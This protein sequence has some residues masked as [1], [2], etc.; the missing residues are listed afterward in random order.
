MRFKSASVPDEMKAIPQWVAYFKK[1]VSGEAHPRKIMVSPNTFHLAKSNVPSDWSDYGKAERYMR[2]RG[3][4]GLAFVLTEGIVF[5][6]LDG[7]IDSDGNI[8]HFATE[9]LSRFSGTYSERS[10]SGHGIHIFARGKLPP[11]SMKRNDALGLEMYETKR[12]CCVTGDAIGASKE[13]VDFSPQIKATAEE[14]LGHKVFVE[15][16]KTDFQ[17]LSMSDQELL[18]RVSKSRSGAKFMKLYAGDASDYPSPS[19][20]DYAF[21]RILSF[22]T[23]SP[24]QIDSLMRG[25]GLFRDKW[26]SPRGE[27]TYGMVTINNALAGAVTVREPSRFDKEMQ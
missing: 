2:Y 14:F 5:M 10:C 25:S 23:S 7:A 20:A 17:A 4:D 27:S 13:I 1:T 11:N 6:D 22:W 24:S 18:D 12:F 8:S 16:R 3:L 26:D 15:P 9:M 19:S 21:C